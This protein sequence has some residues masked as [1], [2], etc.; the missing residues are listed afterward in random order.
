MNK[1]SNNLKSGRMD[2]YAMN[3]QKTCAL[4]LPKRMV[5]KEKCFVLSAQEEY[6]KTRVQKNKRP[7]ARL[8]D[9]Q[10]ESLTQKS[11]NGDPSVGIP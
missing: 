10:F 11:K 1:S 6:L 7:V 4:L 5:Q 8:L 2:Y 9:P 3:M